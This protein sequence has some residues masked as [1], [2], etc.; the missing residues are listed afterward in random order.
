METT[1]PSLLLR[2]RD[3]SDDAAWRVFHRIYRP[4]LIRFA[5]GRGIAP[6]DAEDICQQVLAVVHEEIRDFDYDH[7]L[8]GFKAWLRQL[9]IY[10]VGSLFRRREVRRKG[11]QVLEDR[12][13]R[14]SDGFPSPE[15]SFER[16]WLEEHLWHVLHE[17]AA[18]VEPR[19]MAIY[20][21]LVFAQKPVAELVETYAV[22]EQNI[23]TIKWRLTRRIGARLRELTGE[24]QDDLGT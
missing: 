9:V 7:R 16:I 10:R 1:R 8:G 3:S 13:A 20:K 17:V 12:E 23:Y 21:D 2:I 18:E 6:E 15:E 11:A 5:R 19:T 14:R 4:L 22:T 24:G